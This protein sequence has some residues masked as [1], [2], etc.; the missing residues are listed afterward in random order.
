[1]SNSS[2]RRIRGF[3]APLAGALLWAATGLTPAVAEVRPEHADAA[4]VVQRFSDTMTDVLQHADEL[5]YEGRLERLRGVMGETFDFGFMAEKAIGRFW[6]KLDDNDRERWRST[7]SGFMT[8]NYAG[9]LK[10]NNG[11]RFETLA[12]DVA[13]SNT[14]VIQTR[15][16]DPGEETVDLSY[17][18]HQTPAGWRV[19]DIYLNGTV[20]EL[21][22][23]RADYSAVLKKSGFEAL[24]AS[25]NDKVAELKAGKAA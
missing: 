23:R 1:M 17:R 19:I 16:I 3:T 7:F 10:K 11:Q 12:S 24:V 5:G 9:R 21:A 8:A 18:M 22:L 15:V 4:Q 13:P 6:R 25:V 14:I 20:S 2:R